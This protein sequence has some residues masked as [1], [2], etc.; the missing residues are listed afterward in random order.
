MLF[1]SLEYL[2]FFPI[3]VGL[4]YAFSHKWRWALLL[5]ASYYFYMCWKPEYI[6]LIMAST[7]VDYYA[8]LRMGKIKAKSKR[9]KYLILSI[10][11]NLGILAGFKYFN[12]FGESVNLLFNQVNIFYQVPTFQVLLPVGISFYTFQT[13]SYSIDIYRGITKPEHHLGK[14][15]LFVSFFPQLVAGPIERSNHLLPQIHRKKTFDSQMVISGL[16]L[17]LWGFYKKVVIADRIGIYVSSV[18]ENP[19]EHTGVPVILATALF[20]FQLYCD[21]SAYTDIARGSARIMGYDLMVNFKRPLIAKSI[22]DF[23]QRWHISLTTWFRDY[24]FFA[25][26]AKKNNKILN[27]MLQRNILIT[28]LLM[29]LWHG[30]NWTFIVFGLIHAFYIIFGSLTKRYRDTLNQWIGLQKVPAFFNLYSI[31]VTFGL[32]CFSLFFFRANSISDS[33]MLISRSLHF[34]NIIESFIDV[35][36]NR[37][38]VFVILNIIVLLW[39]EQVHARKNLIEL[40]AN[41]PVIIRWSI[42]LGFI[43]FILIFGMINQQEFIYFQF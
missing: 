6:V 19:T 14:F 27:W 11:V 8:G 24:L 4:Y 39:A 34:G 9:K 23:W 28:Y 35:L 1:N 17:M 38:V 31:L 25:L 18:Y 3:V 40:I 13:M 41:K 22:T 2:I 12:F 37:E 42:Y 30:A 20:A 43:F 7:L 5:L 16:K 10:I 21:F 36:K 26:P 32:L 15:A 29:G 33:F